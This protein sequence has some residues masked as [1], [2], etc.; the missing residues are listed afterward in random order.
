MEKLIV[1]ILICLGPCLNT[2]AQIFVQSSSQQLVEEAVK[3][4]IFLFRQD[5]QVKD[6]A[7]GKYYGRG[8]DVFGSVYALGIKL[9]GGYCL[10]DRG[11]HPWEYDVNFNNYRQDYLPVMYKTYWRET[12][13]TVM[14]DYAQW[15]EKQ[16]KELIPG[17]FSYVTDSLFQ[18]KGFETDLTTGMKAG[19][20]VWVVSEKTIAEASSQTPVSYTI[21]R[22]EL[23]LRE[24][25]G[26]YTLE[27][28][29]TGLNVWGGIYVV[30]VQ[31][32]VGQITF[33]LAGVMD[34][35]GKQWTL[36]TL[37]GKIPVPMTLVPHRAIENSLTPVE[38]VEETVKPVDDDQTTGVDEKG[39]D[40]QEVKGKTRKVKGK[41]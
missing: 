34:K 8:G 13:D 12:A 33:R 20:M 36:F 29:S 18:G 10:S 30:P 21:Y 32:A 39:A 26:E 25:I 17:K 28:P 15:V 22:K 41:R 35:K 38:R 11:I 5:Y 6:T 37:L 31:T 7:T 27:A 16:V 1:S 3:G 9:N 19:W 40:G 2:R 23:E 24:G 4:G 14:A